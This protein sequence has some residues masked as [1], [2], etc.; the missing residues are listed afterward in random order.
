MGGRDVSSP[1]ATFVGYW[2]SQLLPL[3]WVGHHFPTSCLC[4]YCDFKFNPGC[5]PFVGPSRLTLNFS[6]LH[7]L[8]EWV[9]LPFGFLMGLANKDTPFRRLERGELGQT[10]HFWPSS[11]N[12]TSHW[13]CPLTSGHCSLPDVQ[14][15][16][17]VSF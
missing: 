3:P 2:Q 5:T 14:Q 9:R 12:V 13:L 11:C 6:N 10:M 16:M 4:S 17:T 7:E 1:T 8:H 15:Y